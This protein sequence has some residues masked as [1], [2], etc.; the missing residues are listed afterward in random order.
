MNAREESW[1]G[2]PAGVLANVKPRVIGEKIRALAR[3]VCA[4]DLFAELA[5]IAWRGASATATAGRAD[6]WRFVVAL[7]VAI[8]ILGQPLCGKDRARRRRLGPARRGRPRPGSSPVQRRLA[9]I[10]PQWIFEIT[11]LR[12]RKI[13]KGID[14]P[15][16]EEPASYC[17]FVP[18]R[19]L[20][21]ARQIR[22]QRNA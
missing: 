17:R 1:V 5:D 8:S 20:A 22:D 19:A 15:L 14:L 9:A 10:G 2:G 18:A 11:A 12:M 21:G 16:P 7:V 6:W 13:P 4:V 3:I